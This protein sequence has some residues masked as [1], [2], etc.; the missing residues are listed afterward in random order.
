MKAP[1]ILR[2]FCI[3][4]LAGNT[5]VLRLAGQT[6]KNGRPLTAEEG[7]TWVIRWNR[8][9]DFQEEAVDWKKWLK[10]P[11]NF[12]GWTWE[13]EGNMAVKDGV[14]AITLRE[15]SGG[16]TSGMLKSYSKGTYGYFEARIKGTA[17]F[18]GASPAFWHRPMS[19][20]LSL[21]VRAP[22]V[23]WQDNKLVV[24]EEA[25]KGAFPTTMWVDY[26]RVWELEE[27]AE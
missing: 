20:A 27:K 21:G 25:G 4:L 9:D 18:P 8:S 13:N 2:W 24:N 15:G 3:F 19:V 5:G 10:K 11:E 7:E 17:M 23:K 14:L 26:V 6:A 22:H 16:M 12:S 1:S